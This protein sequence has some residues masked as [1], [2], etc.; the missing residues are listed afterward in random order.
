MSVS[1]DRVLYA[2]VEQECTVV[3]ANADRPVRSA[4]LL[5]WDAIEEEVEVGAELVRITDNGLDV[6]SRN[7]FGFRLFVEALRSHLDV[8]DGGGGSIAGGLRLRALSGVFEVCQAGV[9]AS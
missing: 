7:L 2:L 1:P 8:L 6:L 9:A 3:L 4:E 5:A